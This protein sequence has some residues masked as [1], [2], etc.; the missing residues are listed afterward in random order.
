[1]LFDAPDRFRVL[2]LDATVRAVPGPDGKVAALIGQ[3]YGD[4]QATRAVR[5][6]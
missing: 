4:S 5:V 6:P 1:M 2:E 3:S